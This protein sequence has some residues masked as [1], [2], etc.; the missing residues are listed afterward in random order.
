MKIENDKPVDLTPE[1]IDLIKISHEMATAKVLILFM[2]EMI[3]IKPSIL[4]SEYIE[5]EKCIQEY[6]K[7][8]CDEFIKK[9]LKTEQIDYYKDKYKNRLLNTKEFQNNNINNLIVHENVIKQTLT[10]QSIDDI[11][12]KQEIE[13]EILENNKIL[14]IQTKIQKTINSSALINRKKIK[15]HKK[16]KK[17]PKETNIKLSQNIKEQESNIIDPNLIPFMKIDEEKTNIIFP[18]TSLVPESI[19]K[20]Q[21]PMKKNN[22]DK[23]Q[24]VT[25]SLQEFHLNT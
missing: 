10:T 21:K 6:S 2:S 12:R 13:D 1:F 23:Q 24:S 3:L 11:K 5:L 17:T 14:N 25:I 8:Q 4:T 18:T 20:H 16:K 22:P 7:L 15:K 19:T 9:T